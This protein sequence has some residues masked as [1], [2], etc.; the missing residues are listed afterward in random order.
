[1]DE[2][3]GIDL[4]ALLSLQDS[5]ISFSDDDDDSFSSDYTPTASIATATRKAHDQ[6]VMR[7]IS[8]E[9]CDLGM[10]VAH[11]DKELDVATPRSP[12]RQK[13]VLAKTA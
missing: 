6:E 4:S 8:D 13:H 9:A 7:R 2:L 5:G 11:F 3:A 10:L 12:L 1:M